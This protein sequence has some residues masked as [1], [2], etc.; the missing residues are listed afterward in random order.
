MFHSINL[1]NIS[2]LLMI[3]GR[4]DYTSSKVLQ[5]V[6]HGGH[7][8]VTASENKLT[9]DLARVDGMSVIVL[10]VDFESQTLKVR[11]ATEV[12]DVVGYHW[13]GG[14]LGLRESN[15]PVVEF[16]TIDSSVRDQGKLYWHK[17]GCTRQTFLTPR[18]RLAAMVH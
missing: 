6:T 12:V 1:S 7:T 18:A 5:E 8:Y 13:N 16:L 10:E 3:L 2:T 4:E 14:Q 9:V 11:T 17:D 15:D